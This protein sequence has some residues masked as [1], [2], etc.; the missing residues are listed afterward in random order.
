M[1]PDWINGLA[2]G[3]LIGAAAGLLLLG[4]GRIAGVSS[5][6][7]EAV[8]GI[9]GRLSGGLSARWLESLVFVL[10]L[11]AAPAIFGALGGDLE[12]SFAA[13]PATL[14]F[15]GLM[16]GLGTRLG[17]GCTSGHGVSGGARLSRRSFAA[18]ATFMAVAMAT[19]A[20]ARA[21]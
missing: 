20:V 15:A 19:V 2:G 8:E 21:L 18:M 7:G 6:A 12:V 13:G 1:E 5:I 3:A 4:N 9:A 17:S 14:I 10:G 11:L 16:V